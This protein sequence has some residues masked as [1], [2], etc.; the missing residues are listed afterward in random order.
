MM[1][2]TILPD[3]FMSNPV[4]TRSF[5][6]ESYSFREFVDR[7]SREIPAAEVLLSTTLPRGGLQVVQPQKISEN[8]V[9]LY[10]REWQAQDDATW[11]A[12]ATG[13]PAAGNPSERFS[14]DYLSAFGFRY[15]ASAAVSEPV[16]PG[17]AGVL[18]IL[19]TQEQGPVTAA[20]LGR[21]DELAKELA[22]GLK[23]ARA[24]RSVVQDGFV[25]ENQPSDV[26]Q[27][28]LD[29]HG[30]SLIFNDAFGRLDENIRQEMVRE[31]THRA[32]RHQG[33]L[34]VMQRLTMPDSRADH[35][36]VN[37]T[38]YGQYPALSGGAISFFSLLPSCTDW[39]VVRPSDFQADGEM[40]RLVPSMKFMLQEYHRGPTLTEIAKTVHLSPFHFHRRFSELFGLTPKHFLLECQINNAKEELLSGEKELSK[41]ASDCGFAHQSHFTSRFKQATGLTP[42]RWRRMANTRN[43]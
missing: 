38:T 22:T 40:S 13:E 31:A 2:N 33:S 18:T 1:S 16:L 28:V 27:F 19:R 8:F 42:T 12:L 41:I 9:K 6:G 20:E 24:S 39:A 43:G 29:Q 21:L 3:E 26:R 4:S 11:K 30:R 17:Y 14:E 36:V 34:P 35:W 7:L 25:T 23:D 32:T 5:G 15:S 37:V 10:I